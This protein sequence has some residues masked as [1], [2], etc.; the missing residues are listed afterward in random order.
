MI[1]LWRGSLLPRHNSALQ[2]SHDRSH[3]LRGKAYRDALRHRSGRRASRATF[4]R[5]AWERAFSLFSC[6]PRNQSQPCSPPSCWPAHR[7]APGRVLG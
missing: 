1:T 3:A 2:G 5:R 4:P 7:R 6:R